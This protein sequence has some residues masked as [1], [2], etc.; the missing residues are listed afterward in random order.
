MPT[1]VSTA[2]LHQPRLQ[3]PLGAGWQSTLRRLVSPPSHPRTDVNTCNDTTRPPLSPLPAYYLQQSKGYLGPPQPRRD[4]A[5][6]S[7]V[8]RDSPSNPTHHARPLVSAL[9]P[10]C[11][12]PAILDRS[13][14]HSPSEPGHAPRECC[15]G[16]VVYRSQRVVQVDE[17]ALS[18]ECGQSATRAMVVDDD[19]SGITH[20]PVGWT[21]PHSQV[22]AY[23]R[24]VHAWCVVLIA[25]QPRSLSARDVC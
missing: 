13:V 19:S 14:G 11:V 5:P 16:T 10:R 24:G 20:Y 17:R 23:R 1:C 25:G 6:C 22:R 15:T 2:H 4:H 21:L 8:T 12:H 9:P 3:P 18:G 7:Q